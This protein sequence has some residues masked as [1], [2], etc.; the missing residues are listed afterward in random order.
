MV[1]ALTLQILF[2]FLAKGSTHDFKMFK[3]S[4]LLIPQD[5]QILVDLG[6]IG[7]CNIHQN[8]I[9]PIKSSKKKPLTKEDK[10]FN[11]TLAQQR[12]PIENVNRRCK[13]FRITKEVYRGKHKNYGK[14]WHVIAA[15]VNLRYAP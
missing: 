7:I 5:V 11:R 4:Q 3:Q 2:I 15:I 13:I 10:K 12:I 8:S 1:C 14:I 6:Y 9:H